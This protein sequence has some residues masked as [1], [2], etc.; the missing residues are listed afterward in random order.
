VVPPTATAR[1]LP[2]GS[3]RLQ[4]QHPADEGAAPTAVAVRINTASIAAGSPTNAV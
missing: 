3:A 1:G 4:L 2:R